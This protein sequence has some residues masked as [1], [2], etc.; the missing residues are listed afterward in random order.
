MNEA[1]LKLDT[2]DAASKIANVI[3]TPDTSA[4]HD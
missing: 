4:D 2:P 3:A 1:A